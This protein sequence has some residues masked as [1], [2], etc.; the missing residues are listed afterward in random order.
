MCKTPTEIIA[1]RIST[2]FE[3][4]SLLPAEQ[5]GCHPGC[6]CCKDQLIISKAIFED[7]V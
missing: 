1:K 7:S 2:N 5:E 4:Q 6:K 3:E